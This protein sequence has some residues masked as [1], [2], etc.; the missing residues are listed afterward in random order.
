M[1]G[2][3]LDV[4]DGQSEKIESNVVLEPAVNMS[5]DSESRM[6][7]GSV[8]GNWKLLSSIFVNVHKLISLRKLSRDKRRK[9]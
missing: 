2:L 6:Q 9:Y 5:V 3:V 7:A 8:R 1:V 4:D